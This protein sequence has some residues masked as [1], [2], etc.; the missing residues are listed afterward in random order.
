MIVAY[1]TSFY[2]HGSHSFIRREIAGVEEHGF[3]VLRF[4]LRPALGLVD[5][6]D[7]AEEKRTTVL[8]AFG[9]F[10]IIAA[11]LAVAIR[12]PLRFLR[13]SRLAVRFG[14]RSPRGVVRHLIYLAESCL[15]LRLMREGNVGHL[16]AHFGTN[17]ASIALFA[18]HARRAAI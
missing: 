18:W 7:I 2:P 8:V 4:S 10:R 15:L 14:R 6:A 12:H 5:P 13:T 9:V 11:A 17:P 3:T 16:H 1:L